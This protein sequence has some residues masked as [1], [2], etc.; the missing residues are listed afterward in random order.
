MAESRRGTRRVD[1]L[2][3]VTSGVGATTATARTTPYKHLLSSND[4]VHRAT[5]RLRLVLEA[6]HVSVGINSNR[7]DP[8]FLHPLPTLGHLL[9][10][11]DQSEA[12][13]L[14][15]DCTL[16]QHMRREPLP[17]ASVQLITSIMTKASAVTK[18]VSHWHSL[19]LQWSSR[20]LKPLSHHRRNDNELR[21]PQHSSPP[22]TLTK[23]IGSSARNLTSQ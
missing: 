19:S 16:H 10:S 17:C 21:R 3:G 23:R 12:C 18:S 15:F 7:R 14:S 6:L 11:S 1:E 9:T 13:P 4:C 2:A 22:S 5:R 8:R 20:L